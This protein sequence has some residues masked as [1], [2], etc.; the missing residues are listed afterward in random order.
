MSKFRE[1]LQETNIEQGLNPV[2]CFCLPIFRQVHVCEGLSP[3]Y[4]KG[5]AT[6]GFRMPGMGS[7]K[8]EG[9]GSATSQGYEEA[10]LSSFLSAV[11]ARYSKVRPPRSRWSLS[12]YV[13]MY[14]SGSSLEI[15]IWNVSERL[16]EGC[17]R[18]DTFL[19]L[20]LGKG[21]TDSLIPYPQVRVQQKY[22]HVKDLRCHKA[23]RQEDFSI[24]L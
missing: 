1:T 20:Q 5:L 13:C 24:W 8:A 10:R 12:N 17:G 21:K 2:R 15:E 14:P 16:V 7:L 23:E 3:C 18:N 4:V 19:A 11:D 6:S 22:E 9:C